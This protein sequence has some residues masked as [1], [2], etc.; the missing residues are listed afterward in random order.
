M[1]KEDMIFQ[2]EEITIV[3][4]LKQN[5]SAFWKIIIHDLIE[6]TDVN[7]ISI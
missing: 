3:K 5:R 2:G 7:I 1:T 4:T 6:N